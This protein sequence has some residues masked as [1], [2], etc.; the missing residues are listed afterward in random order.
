ME[1]L[2][3]DAQGKDDFGD[4]ALAQDLLAEAEKLDIDLSNKEGIQKAA[5]DFIALVDGKVDLPEN[6]D[7]TL[8]IGKII[9][10]NKQKSKKEIMEAIFEKFGF[11]EA[12]KQKAAAKEAAVDATI[13]NPKNTALLLALKECGEVRVLFAHLVFE[14]VISIVSHTR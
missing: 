5:K 10:N 9:V 2:I 6:R 4:D 12:K 11:A 13:A 1:K 14:C 3:E 8:E 7:P